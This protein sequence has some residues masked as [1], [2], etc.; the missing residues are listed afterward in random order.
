MRR[1]FLLLAVI[2]LVAGAP[3]GAAAIAVYSYQ[4]SNFETIIDGDELEGTYTTDMR[5]T[6]FFTLEEPLAPD[7]SGEFITLSV[8]N[9]SF[10]DGRQQIASGDV[11][12][13]ISEAIVSTDAD[14]EISQWRFLLARGDV[15]LISTQGFTVVSDTASLCAPGSC[16][17]AELDIASFSGD[18]GTW[19]LAPEPGTGAL[20]SLGL[21]GVARRRRRDA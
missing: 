19:T 12:S 15:G 4:G 1:T 2:C 3:G 9:F 7:L 10:E 20:L 17:P 8:Q 11:E 5:V 13:R 21:G 16:D 18:N 14:G 6:G